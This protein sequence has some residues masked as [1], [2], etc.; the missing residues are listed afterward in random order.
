[1]DAN[2]PGAAGPIGQERSTGK[3]AGSTG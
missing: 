1:M 2:R 3:G